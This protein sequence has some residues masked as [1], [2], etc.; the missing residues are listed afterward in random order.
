VS[1]SAGR[2]EGRLSQGSRPGLHSSA[3]TGLSRS[4][5]RVPHAWWG[6]GA[7]YRAW[8]RRFYPFGVY[9][10]KKR[11]EKLNYAHR[12]AMKNGARQL[13][14]PVT[15]S[16]SAG[17]LVTALVGGGK[18]YWLVTCSRSAGPLATAFLLVVEL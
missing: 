11:L 9:S 8:Q 14:L 16:R 13:S 2:G 5:R 18:W 17:S 10:E 4:V 12:N 7:H 1:R 3:P 6:A 15:C